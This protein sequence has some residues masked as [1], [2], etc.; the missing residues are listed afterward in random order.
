MASAREDRKLPCMRSRRD[1]RS[2][3]SRLA[4]NDCGVTVT[5]FSEGV[6][7]T[8][9]FPTYKKKKERFNVP[10]QYLH[11]RQMELRARQKSIQTIAT[12]CDSVNVTFA[13]YEFRLF[14][15]NSGNHTE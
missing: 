9:L 15:E 6:T 7:P 11:R 8:K 1:S 3:K 12:D 5:L 10:A 14:I 4:V 2:G 13:T